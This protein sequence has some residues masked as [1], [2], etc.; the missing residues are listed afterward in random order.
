M[1]GGC[2]DACGAPPGNAAARRVLWVALAINGA[3][4]ALEVAAGLAAHSAS[5]KADALDFLGDSATYA[6][7]LAVLDRALAW[8]T[9]AAFCKGASLLAL[10]LWVLANTALMAFAGTLPHAETMGAIGVLAFVANLATAALL[11]RHRAGDANRRSAWIC[12]RNDAI[13]NLAVLAAAFGVFGTK[14]A[15]PDSAVAAVLAALAVSGGWQILREAWGE[16]RI[17]ASSEPQCDAEF[18]LVREAPA[19]AA[20]AAA[21][22]L[23]SSPSSTAAGLPASTPVRRS[24]TN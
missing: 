13:G 23:S 8:R 2:C 17:G 10:G 12:S 19:R 24:F 21:M 18:G 16:L 20:S 15:W 9:R 22:K 14:T 11:W 1:A 4:F 6:I 3:M 5:L 7:S